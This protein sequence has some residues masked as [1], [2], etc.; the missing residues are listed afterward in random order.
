MTLRFSKAALKEFFKHTHPDTLS[1]APRKIKAANTTAIRTINSYID[2]L[3]QGSATQTQSFSFFTPSGGDYISHHVSLR[4]SA[5]GASQLD[6]EAL[7]NEAVK[8]LKATMKKS[9]KLSQEDIDE[10]SKPKRYEVTLRQDVATDQIETYLKFIVNKT[11]SEDRAFRINTRAASFLDKKLFPHDPRH[12][13][14]P[15]QTPSAISKAVLSHTLREIHP[16]K[17]PINCDMVYFEKGVTLDQTKEFIRRI[18]ADYLAPSKTLAIRRFFTRF[19][20]S[21]IHLMVGAE[22]SVTK[23]PGFLTLPFDFE[24]EAVEKFYDENKRDLHTQ[25]FKMQNTKYK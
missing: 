22:Y 12:F 7:L 2:A 23:N 3:Q 5:A 21:N 19:E 6:R 14:L 10:F 9:P 17:L 4:P 20:Q 1:S 18:N 25:I 16:S 13:G 11:T 8:T 24:F 15:A